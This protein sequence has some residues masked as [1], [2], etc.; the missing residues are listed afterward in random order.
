MSL[1]QYRDKRD[2]IK[3][4][5]IIAVKKKSAGIKAKKTSI[6]TSKNHNRQSELKR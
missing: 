2:I 5:F 6:N 4:F 3:L 1:A